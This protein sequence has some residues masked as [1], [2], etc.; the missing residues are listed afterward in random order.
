MT[1][2]HADY[3]A[4]LHNDPEV[5]AMIGGIRSAD[6]SAA[7]L[8]SNLE[9]WDQNGFGQW[10]FRDE[11]SQLVGRGGLRW[12]DP[13]VGEQIVEIGYV[14]QRSAWGAG[15]ATEAATA[16]AAVARDDYRLR[17][18]GAITLEGNDA[19]ARVLTKSGFVFQRRVMHPRGPHRYFRLT[20]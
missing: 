18:L 4:Q 14:L 6:E 13:C 9:H 2:A 7:W 19:S 8:A 12:I 16:I 11:T 3:L 5:M 1:A 10:M 20:F 15:L 17:E